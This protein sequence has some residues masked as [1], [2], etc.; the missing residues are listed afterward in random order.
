V[1]YA[2]ELVKTACP[3][4]ILVFLKNKGNIPFSNSLVRFI[5]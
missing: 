3:K 2:E 4:A 5:L 1:L